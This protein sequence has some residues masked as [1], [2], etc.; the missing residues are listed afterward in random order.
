MGNEEEYLDPSEE[1]KEQNE[2]E[3]LDNDLVE[4]NESENLIESQGK[5]FVKNK[6]KRYLKEKTDP[7]KDKVKNKFGNK[8]KPNSTGANSPLGNKIPK[9]PMTSPAGV[10]GAGGATA[11]T[12]GAAAGAT[13]TAGTGATATT[14]GAAATTAGA[15][16]TTAGAAATTAGAAATTATGSA[17]GSAVVALLANPVTWIVLGIILLLIIIIV[18]VANLSTQVG[19]YPYFELEKT[20]DTYEVVEN[21]I[22]IDEGVDLEDL[23]AISL[24]SEA[25][26]FSDAPEFLKA[27]AIAIRSVIVQRVNETCVLDTRTVAY[28]EAEKEIALESDSIYQETVRATKGLILVKDEE[29]HYGEFSALCYQGISGINYV[30]GYGSKTHATMQEQ[31]IPQ[32]FVHRYGTDPDW[33]NDDKLC[34]QNNHGGMSQFGGAHLAINE[35]YLFDQILTYYYNGTEIMTINKSSSSNYDLS[36]PTNSEGILNVPLYLL[37]EKE[38]SNLEDFNELIYDEVTDYDL[39]SRD[40]VVEAGVTLVNTL[41]LDY[42]VKIPYTYSGG[43]SS[44][45]IQGI[46]TSNIFSFYGADKNW[47]SAFSGGYFYGG[48]GPYT[49][50]GPDC[51][52]FV[53]WTFRNAGFKNSA[54]TSATQGNYGEKYK[55]FSGGTSFEAMPGDLVWQEG[56][57]MLIV[58]TD[59]D[60]EQITIAHATG[61]GID[62]LVIQTISTTNSKGRYAVDMSDYYESTPYYTETEFEDVYFSGTMKVG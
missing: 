39:G 54:G 31:L 21:G 61:G 6:A 1:D 48:Y 13:A 3:V 38:G 4:D 53:S 56:H 45:S 34:N 58:G 33:F 12:G 62:S 27:Q 10:S 16:A 44:T 2:E 36:M 32:T 47:G 50:Y 46:Q 22:T 29:V 17:I 15:A 19:Q 7:V 8:F 18:V 51:S 40:A 9:S 14:A 37:L 23:V 43:H 5:E 30:V 41:W 42:G 57:I 25:S 28:D 55:L 24:Y 60:N 20:C 26:V 49:G 11:G 52:S 35:T 59:Y